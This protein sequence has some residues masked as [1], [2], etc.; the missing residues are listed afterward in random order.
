MAPKAR[1][2]DRGTLLDALDRMRAD[3]EQ[4]AAS[5]RHVVGTCSAS[6]KEHLGPPSTPLPAGGLR[7]LES[8]YRYASIEEME[9]HT[10]GGIVK[11]SCALAS[12]DARVLEGVSPSKG[13]W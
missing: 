9:V 4:I 3:V 1:R 7:D 8:V 12:L 6:G 5:D 2:E 10:P 13:N 11:S